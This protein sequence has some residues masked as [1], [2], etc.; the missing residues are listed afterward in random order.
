MIVL[1]QLQLFMIHATRAT[2]MKLAAM[3]KWH[4]Q[5]QQDDGKSTASRHCRHKEGA[6]GE[7]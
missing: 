1:Q 6:T 5:R 4:H 3:M 2:A 7:G